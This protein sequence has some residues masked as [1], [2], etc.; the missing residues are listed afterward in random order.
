MTVPGIDIS[1][2]NGSNID[3]KKV[4][5]A[6]KQ[7]AFM[8]VNEG[9][10]IDQTTT[11]ARV[12]A[13]R[14]AGL[15]VGGYDFLRPK[16]GRTGAQEFDIFYKRAHAVG[17]LNKGCLRPVADVEASGFTV[18]R[19]T[20]TR[21]YIKSWVNRCFKVTGYHPIIYTGHFWRE[22]LGDWNNNLGCVL[23]LAAYTANWKQ[24]IPKAWHGHASFHQ[25]SESGRIPGVPGNCD[26]DTYLS[27]LSVLKHNHTLKH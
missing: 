25:Y 7:F 9:D 20:R 23:W 21:A 4:H 1:N 19:Q 2:S 6:G 8:K 17:L 16:T 22:D 12:K 11:I 18:L 15:L 27:D 3:W 14:N 24:Y 5:Y 10:Y 13:A 26:L